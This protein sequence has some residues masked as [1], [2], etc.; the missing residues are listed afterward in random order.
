M[1]ASPRTKALREGRAHLHPA[2]RG[3]LQKGLRVGVCHNEFN[4]FKAAF[5]HVVDGIAPGTANP[6]YRDTR[7]ELVQVGDSEID[8]H[9]S[10]P[11][12]IWADKTLFPKA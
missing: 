8:G 7:L 9:E 6:K 1:A 3:V 12:L 4:A 2:L 10:I 11:V 5:D